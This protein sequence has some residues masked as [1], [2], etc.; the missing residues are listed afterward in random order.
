GRFFVDASGAESHLS[1]SR[2]RKIAS[3]GLRKISFFAHYE[4]VR[5][6]VEGS[7]DIAIAVLRDGWAWLIP[8]DDTT[9]SFGV[10]LDVDRWNRENQDRE[11]FMESTIL[12]SPYLEER[13]ADARRVSE[14][15]ARKNFSYAVDRMTGPNF[16]LVG[17]AAGFIDPI[18]STGVFMAM[19]SAE[20]ASEAVGRRLADGSS[21][22]LK[23]YEKKMRRVLRRYLR[24]IDH[25]YRREFI[26]VF[27]HPQPRFGLVEVIIGLLAGNAFERVASRWK[28]ELF[29]LLVW[30]QRWTRVIAPPVPWDRLPAVGDRRISEVNVV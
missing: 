16:A 8:I 9:T 1:S 11:S 29:Y 21:A 17:D 26:E 7:T 20:I 6:S 30:M 23:R 13:M 12:G 3:E 19:R 14:V 15:R 4:G 25:F 22:D 18:F 5:P 27:L 10:V 28:L 24:I 2:V